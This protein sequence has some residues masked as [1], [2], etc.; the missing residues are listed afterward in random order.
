MC[1]LAVKWL[2]HTTRRTPV[3][4]ALLPFLDTLEIPITF[5]PESEGTYSANLVI[6][7]ANDADETTYTV[8]LYGE[9][10]DHIILSVPDVYVTIQEAIIAAHP[11]D[12]VEVGSGT[13]E[14]SIDLL[15]KDLVVR[16]IFG[17]DSTL[18]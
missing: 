14:E 15:D 7:S 8:Q 5:A 11:E 9:S 3:E 2:W 12:T 17:P 13:Y 18:I 1:S 6:N 4:T 10:S 16:S